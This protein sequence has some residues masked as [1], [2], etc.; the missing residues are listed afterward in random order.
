MT[1]PADHH[2][3]TPTG[4]FVPASLVGLP[5]EVILSWVEGEADPGV[6]A[7][8]EAAMLHDASA[9]RWLIGMR[10]DRRALTALGDVVAPADL[11]EAVDRRQR[12][13]ALAALVDGE[14]VHDSLPI[15][16]FGHARKPL[17][18]S[19][20]WRALAMA[21]GFALAIGG[22]AY[23]ATKVSLPRFEIGQ[24][25]RSSE[26]PTHDSPVIALHH[27]RSDTITNTVDPGFLG[28]DSLTQDSPLL[29]LVIP[30][31]AP[32]ALTTEEA[33]ALAAERRLCIRLTCET[34]AR[35]DVRVT[36]L[37]RAGRPADGWMVTTKAPP[38]LAQSV[39]LAAS[40]GASPD[41]EFTSPLASAFASRQIPLSV[42]EPPQV[43]PQ[44]IQPPASVVFLADAR[45]DERSLVSLLS[46][47][48][49]GRGV[50]VRLLV[51]PDPWDDL[52]IP[53]SPDSILWWTTDPANWTTW[54]S[55]PIV[56]DLG[57]R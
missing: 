26:T 50:S 43:L 48:E 53:A 57:T 25:A 22:A 47:L 11:L 34:V 20:Q 18:N 42:I 23:L 52:H 49:A 38:H 5:E 7:R 44:P 3:T 21:A 2:D 17:L 32:E 12:E 41:R 27:E 33:L 31:P 28:S 4:P 13:T 37:A 45:L 40:S 19:R 8:I 29:A 24:Q 9:A 54:T 51:L 10:A 16:K 39:V 15:S 1:N 30:D 14:P 46:E 56:V 55:I 35:F 36:S 6:T